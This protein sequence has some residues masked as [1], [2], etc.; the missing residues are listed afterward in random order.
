MLIRWNSSFL[1]I[2][3]LILHKDVLNSMCSFLN[4]ITG[5]T[6]K[7]TKKLMG[8]MLNQQEWNL[9]NC[10]KNVLEPFLEATT[11]LSGQKYP[12]MA[13]SFCFPSF[14]TFSTIIF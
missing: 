8:L 7:Q 1:L 12:T 5:L 2:D 9:L 4:N 13:L 11:A 3:R 10:L 14:I 6:E